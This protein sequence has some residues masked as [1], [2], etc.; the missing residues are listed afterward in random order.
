[1][2]AAEIV[3]VANIAVAATFATGYLIIALT[4]WSQRRAL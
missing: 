4:T 1:M 2:N 3:L